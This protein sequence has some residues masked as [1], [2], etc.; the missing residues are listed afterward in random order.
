MT[1]RSAAGQADTSVGPIMVIV[2]TTVSIGI[3]VLALVVAASRRRR[4]WSVLA[5]LGLVVG[6][7]SVA[8]PLGVEAD[9]ATKVALGAM[10]LLTG[11]VWFGVLRSLDPTKGTPVSARA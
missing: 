10:H 2:T 6:V 9:A 1:V 8:M 11:A 4:A 5:W 3:G 7:V